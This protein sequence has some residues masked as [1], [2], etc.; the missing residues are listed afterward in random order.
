MCGIA[1]ILNSE[2][3]ADVVRRRLEKL[4]AALRD[5]GPDDSGIFLSRDGH[6]GLAQTRLSILDLSPAGHQPMA[7]TDGRFQIGLWCS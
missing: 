2:L 4:T 5:R 7:S 3:S 6:T 1:G